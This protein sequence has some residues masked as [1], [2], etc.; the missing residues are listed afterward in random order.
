MGPILA[1]SAEA[2][3]WWSFM[4]I[5]QTDRGKARAYSNLLESLREANPEWWPT[6]DA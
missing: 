2:W 6:V 5:A 3:I 1:F 4:T